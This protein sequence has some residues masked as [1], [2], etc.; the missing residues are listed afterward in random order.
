MNIFGEVAL[1]TISIVG[2]AGALAHWLRPL[3]KKMEEHEPASTA[4]RPERSRR[5]SG[6]EDAGPS[7]PI[8]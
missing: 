4:E 6:S 3:V 1:W 8:P 5:K 7:K 2:L